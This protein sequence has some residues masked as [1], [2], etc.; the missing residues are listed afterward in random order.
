[1]LTDSLKQKPL[2]KQLS[3][4]PKE[5]K[6][7]KRCVVS[8][9]RPRMSIDEEGVCSACRFTEMKKKLIDW[10]VR[11]R[12]FQILLDKHRCNDGRWDV[13]VPSSGGKDSSYVA[14]Q[15]KHR[16]GMH[17]VTVTWAPFVYTDIGFQNFQ[18][19]V[20]S[21]FTNIKGS[22]NGKIHRKL[23]RLSFE[24]VGDNFLPFIYGQ[25]CFVFH[26]ASKLGIKLVLYGENGDAE[27][28]GNLKYIDRPDMPLENFEIGYWK[29]T[30]VDE[31]IKYGLESN[32]DYISADDFH[33]SDLMF[34]R[35]PSIGELKKTNI[36]F[37][38]YSYY[39][40]WIPQEN[41]NYSSKHL[42]FRA[43]PER[44]EGTYSKYAR[45]DDRLDGLH[46]YMAFIKF[47]IGR[48]TADVSQ[49]IRNG[50]LTRE[51][52]IALVK[53]YDA[54]FPIKYFKETLEYLGITEKHFWEVVD[55]FRQ[56]HLWK[57][58]NGV[59]KL[60]HQVS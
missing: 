34:Y 41:Y 25:F 32:K 39:H 37:H 11:E 60:K 29:G 50:Q 38:W 31:L 49:E 10:N 46:F 54:E 53:R 58:V 59:W 26:M 17:P 15:L 13:V 20:S 1:M 51:E 27:Y 24:E 6:F 8:N 42:G 35:Y 47:G 2:E 33:D 14:Y 30:S 18:S 23:A 19:F 56:P 57:K 48:A 21:G 52:G 43:N 4:L 45:L 5:V 3:S 9:Q 55:S 28:G 40:N 12:D 16:Y 36:Q 7:C 44:S 22:P